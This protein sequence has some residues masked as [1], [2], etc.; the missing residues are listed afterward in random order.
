MGYKRCVGVVCAVLVSWCL[1]SR[2]TSADTYVVDTAHTLVGFTVRHLVINKVRGKFNEFIGTITYDEQ[3][4]SKSSLQGSIR[5]AS[6]D[7]DNDKRDRHLRSP[8]FFNAATYPAITFTTT[9]IEPT[10]TGYS[11]IGDLTIRATT[12]EVVIPFNITG[13]I[14]DPGGKTR[15]GFEAV[16]RI[17]RQDYGV[18][19]NKVLDNGGL[20]VGNTVDIE[21]IGEAIK[22]EG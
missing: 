12:K 1:T 3:D 10:D 9:R 16:L 20:V 6:V 5:V 14:V 7:T 13:K 11:L 19:Y 8:D 2:A 18:S 21:L 15:I 17:N 22:Q 4:L